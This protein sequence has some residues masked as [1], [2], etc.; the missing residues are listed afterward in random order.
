VAAP[1]NASASL[2]NDMRVSLIVMA[3]LWNSRE[4]VRR[5]CGRRPVWAEKP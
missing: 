3:V 4:L 2:N 5:G 1:T